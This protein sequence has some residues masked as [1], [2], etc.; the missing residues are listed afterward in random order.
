MRR[1]LRTFSTSSPAFADLDGQDVGPGLGL[2]VDP[3]EGENARRSPGDRPRARPSGPGR[4]P[5]P[6]GPSGPNRGRQGSARPAGATCRPAGRPV[7]R[8]GPSGRLGDRRRR[9][10]ARTSGRR[11]ED[12]RGRAPPGSLTPPP[13]ARSSSTP[14]PAAARCARPSSTTSWPLTMTW[15]IPSG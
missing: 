10:R 15:R 8:P 13:P 5:R 7:R 12:D 6:T 3:E 9:P 2:D 11:P 14:C 1:S 4:S